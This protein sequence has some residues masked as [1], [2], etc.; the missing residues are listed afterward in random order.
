[1]QTNFDFFSV[2]YNKEFPPKLI[3][4]NKTRQTISIPVVNTEG[5][6]SSKTIFY[7]YDGDYFIR[8]K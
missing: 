6:V 1:M 5:K 7:K 2:K 8:M 3:K 4:F